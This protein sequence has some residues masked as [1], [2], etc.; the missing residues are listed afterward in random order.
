M[1]AQYDV[2]VVGGGHAGCEAAA[3]AARMGAK[4]ALVTHRFATIGAMSCNPAIGGLG[5]GHLVREIDALDGLMGRVAD[6]GGIQFRV[7]NRRKGPAV[8]GPRAQADRKLYATAMQHAISAIPNLTVVPAEAD[9]VIIAGKRIAGLKLAD[10]RELG[11]GAVVLTTGTFLRGL[12]HIGERKTPAGRVGEAPT[13]GLSLTLERLG[14]AL[15]RLKTGTPPRLDG[16]SIDWTAVEMQPGDEPPEPFSMLT[17]QIENPQVQCGIT[18]TNSAT[19]RIIRDNVHRSPMYSGQ[20]LSKGP[21]YCPSIEDKIVRFGERDGHQIFLEPEGLEDPTVYPNGISTSLPE[22]VQRALVATIAGLKD[23]RMVR[24]GYAIEYDHVDPRELT[25]TLETKR[26]PGLFLAGQ[27]NGT[28]GYEEAAAQGLV[29][30]LN[31][32]SQAGGGGDITF[33]RAEAYLAVMIDDLVTRGVTEPYRMFTSRAEYRLT[34]RADNADQRLT[35]RGI[36]IGCVGARRRRRHETKMAALATARDF[37]RS[38]SLTPSE[39]DRYGLTLNKDG[40]RRSA[41]E[42]L[43]H[44]NIEMA[45]LATIW[46]QFADLPPKIAEQLEI[47]AKYDVYLSRQA[48]DIAAYRRDERLELPEGLDYS[49]I[50][51]LSTEVRQRLSSA[52]PRTIS[53]AARMDGITPAALTLLVAHLKRNSRRPK[54]AA[55]GN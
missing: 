33:D 5:K 20:I 12:I 43:S 1:D 23:A 24:A 10:G 38:V 25:P 53:Q 8:R 29:A 37:A 44:P 26:M 18:R 6:L 3:A 15:G 31:A 32:A 41:F 13:V 46:P 17:E 21:R 36:A 39:A 4:T 35:A 30:G 19:H 27:I 54:A 48:A 16:R 28:T 47:D 49:Q 51:G 7:L 11:A 42:L 45:E 50:G 40:Q 22:E 2:V 9:D 14:F 52:R 34:L 55:G